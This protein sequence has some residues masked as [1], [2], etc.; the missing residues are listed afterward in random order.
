MEDY[1]GRYKNWDNFVN[2]DNLEKDME[3]LE[4][5]EYALLHYGDI[6]LPPSTSAT[7]ASHLG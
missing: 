1:E 2:D 7:S 3:A 5:R 6:G 4:N